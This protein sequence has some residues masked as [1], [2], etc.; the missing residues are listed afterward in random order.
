MLGVDGPRPV[1]EHIHP[2]RI[3][4]AER[5][6]VGHDVEDEPHGSV[7]QG[8]DESVEASSTAQFGVEPGRVD[9]V[10]PVRAPGPRAKKRRGVDVAHSEAIEIRDEVSAADSRSS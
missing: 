5:H 2:P 1:S 8:V 10:V 7:V 4:P 9:D 3:V 6:V